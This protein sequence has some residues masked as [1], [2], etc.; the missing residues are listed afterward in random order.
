[1]IGSVTRLI[2]GA[3]E[4]LFEDADLGFEPG[5]AGIL[6]SL[7]LLGGTEHGVVK[8]GLLSS[9]KEQRAIRTMRASAGR[10]RVEEVRCVDASRRRVRRGLCGGWAGRRRG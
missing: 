5:D 10:K 4:A 6:G 9:L 3:V 7:A 2:L 8:V 1:M